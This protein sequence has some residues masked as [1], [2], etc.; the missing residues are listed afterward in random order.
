MGVGTGGRGVIGA[1]VGVVGVAGAVPPGWAGVD[2]GA[3]AAEGVGSSLM[4]R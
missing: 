3:G 2:P 1:V 4:G